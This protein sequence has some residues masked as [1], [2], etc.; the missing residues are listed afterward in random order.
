M[1][2]SLLFFIWIN[3]YVLSVSYIVQAEGLPQVMAESPLFQAL[4]FLIERSV[5][6]VNHKVRRYN[7]KV[8]KVD[9]CDI[10]RCIGNSADKLRRDAAYVSEDNQAE[11]GQAH[12]LRAFRLKVLDKVERP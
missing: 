3:T 7:N 10:E 11:K 4:S 6:E 12:R 8:Y 5:I 9:Y 1:S 2:C